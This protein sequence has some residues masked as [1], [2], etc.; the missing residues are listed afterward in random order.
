METWFTILTAGSLRGYGAFYTDDLAD[1]RRHIHHG[2]NGFMPH[3]PLKETN[4]DNAPHVLLCL[5]GKFKGETG[6]RYHMV[7]LASETMSGIP[8]RWWIEKLIRVRA[9]E[10]YVK[11]P[12][13]GNR[14]GTRNLSLT[15]SHATYDEGFRFYLKRV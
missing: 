6:H 7:G 5:M 11:R 14:D 8:V 2:R 3:R 10:G 12:A 15:A 13:L 1:L 4:L 9:G